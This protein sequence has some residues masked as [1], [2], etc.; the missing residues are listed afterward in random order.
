MN[1]SFSV[2]LTNANQWYNL[3]DFITS[4]PNFDPTMSNGIYYPSMA[5][6]LKIQ[7]DNSNTG[8]RLTVS[9]DIKK[10]GGIE[11]AADGIEKWDSNVNS[12]DIKGFFL[13]T[14]VGGAQ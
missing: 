3:W 7:S 13:K 2:T 10:L 5:S 4:L 6:E 9:Q 1:R 11:I 14:D 12:I 8:K